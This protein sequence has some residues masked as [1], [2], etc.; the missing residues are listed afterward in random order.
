MLNPETWISATIFRSHAI[1]VVTWYDTH[2]IIWTNE[3]DIASIWPFLILKMLRA[4]TA[5]R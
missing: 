2:I 1:L 5:I 3:L 4:V